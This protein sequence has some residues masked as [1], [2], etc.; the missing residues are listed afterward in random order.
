MTKQSAGTSSR[1]FKALSNVASG[2][3]SDP[4]YER[5]SV[6]PWD[7]GDDDTLLLTD[8]QVVDVEKG[9][10]AD[11]R[12]VVVRG[13]RIAD[14]VMP[15]DL[16]AARAHHHVKREFDCGGHYLIP[17]LSDIH[18]HL[19]LVSEF[20]VGIGQIRHLD[21]QRL[22]NSEAAL[23]KGCTFVRDCGTALAPINFTR[24]EIEA[25]RLLG[26][27]IMTSTNAISPRGGMWDVGRV[28]NTLAEPV[29]GG[30][31][32]H[33]PSGPRELV[34]VMTEINGYGCD[35]FKV[36]FEERPLYGGKE[37]DVFTMFTPE[38][39]QLIRQTA[40][41]FGKQVSAHTMFIS[42]T[43]RAI[44]AG[45]DIVDHCTTDEPFSV[46]DAEKMADKGTAIVPTLSLGTYLAM[47]CG[48]RGYPEDP[49]VRFFAEQRET[50]GRRHAQHVAVP[51][52]RKSYERFFDWLGEAQP[53]RKMPMIG[54]VWPERVHG[55]AH[56]ARES[57]E[58][59]RSAGVR[60]GVGTDGG[61]G[62]TFCGHLET[63]L[64]SLHRYGFSNGQVLRMAT[65]GNMEIVGREG[66][67]G[68]LEK[69]KLADMVVLRDNPLQDVSAVSTV[70]MV[71]K[72]GRLYYENP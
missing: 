36:Y 1:F 37:D 31:L 35:F 68:S 41:R 20:G 46:G 24:A 40:D 60:V 4:V 65:L 47:N 3:L 52:L 38:E 32:L 62:I 69:G 49:E 17:G 51:E 58:K 56:H 10:L 34:R 19:C 64:E 45:I 53:D 71:F 5:E 54:S 44:E 43:R 39:A 50:L 9:R 33:F 42:G 63:E 55:F 22:R 15:N 27:R 7:L 66:E 59:L 13:R 11:E 70:L 48:S 18:C 25:D 57:I 6:P 67:L 21:S 29:F 2:H 26:P 61:T 72:D 16:S 30:R 14:L 8:V 12:H 28:M 23:Q